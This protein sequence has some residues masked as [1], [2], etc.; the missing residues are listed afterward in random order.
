MSDDTRFEEYE[1]K[2]RKLILIIGGIFGVLFLFGLLMLSS[3]EESYTQ[4]EVA[5]TYVENESALPNIENEETNAFINT[6]VGSESE[7]TAD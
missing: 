1:K 6:E 4:E 3:D 7:K 2:T 5:P